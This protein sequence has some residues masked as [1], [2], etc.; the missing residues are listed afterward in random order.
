MLHSGYD[1]SVEGQQRKRERDAKLLRLDLDENPDHP[2]V[3]FNL[4]MTDHFLGEH[5]SAIE[6]LERSIAVAQGNES[7]IRKAYSLLGIS[8]R[9]LHG[10]IEGIRVFETGLKHVG[11]DPELWFHLAMTNAQIGEVDQ[12]IAAYEMVLA[13][14]PAGF[15]SS[16]DVAIRGHKTYFNL[17]ALHQQS[18]RYE[19]AA[20]L[21]KK[22]LEVSPSFTPAAFALFDAALV[23]SDRETAVGMCNHIK[24]VEEDKSNYLLMLD[25]LG[26]HVAV[27]VQRG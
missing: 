25:R 17:A 21:W 19:R 2:F 3:L 12:A 14:E 9:E 8:V 18:G 4:G 7:H 16:Y 5:Q 23:S 13:D 1:T 10:P 24:R 11:W 6:W 22:C 26:E 20:A 15:Y 27:A